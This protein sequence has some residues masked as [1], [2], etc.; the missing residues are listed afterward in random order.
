[1]SKIIDSLVQTSIDSKNYAGVIL[2]RLHFSPIVRYANTYQPIYWDEGTPVGE[3][4]YLGLGNLAGI[5]VLPETNELGSQ[6]IQLTL[7]GIPASAITEAFS[8]EYLGKPVFIWYATLDKDTYAVEGGQTGPVLV[9]AGRMD[10]AS[11]E[12][13]DTCTITVNATSRLADWDRPRGGRFNHTYQTRHVD[14]NDTGFKY[15]QALQNRAI[16]WGS[17]SLEDAGGPTTPQNDGLNGLNR[18]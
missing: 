16:S 12:F 17:V 1:M 2:A 11:L 10:F 15:V 9:F 13:G 6:T 4:P 5:S 3:V 8:D 14:I 18:F 7:S